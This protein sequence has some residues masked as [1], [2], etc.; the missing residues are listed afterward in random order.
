MSD[1]IDFPPQFV[2]RERR[3]PDL[4]DKE[5]R[6]YWYRR[7]IRDMFEMYSILHDHSTGASINDLKWMQGEKVQREMMEEHRDFLIEMMKHDDMLLE[8]AKTLAYYFGYEFG[9][10][11]A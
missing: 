8:E 10:D 1:I 9:D 11:L 3:A 4:T 2:I 6:L 5:A 7:A